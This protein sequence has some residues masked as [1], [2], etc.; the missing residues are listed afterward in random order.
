M[1]RFERGRVAM[2]TVE[3]RWTHVHDEGTLKATLMLETHQWLL[4]PKFKG[5]GRTESHKLVE[6]HAPSRGHK[7]LWKR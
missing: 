2:V 6:S 1:D 5:T 7:P 4:V 3:E